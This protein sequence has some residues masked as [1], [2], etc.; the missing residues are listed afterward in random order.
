[1]GDT[2]PT[3][4]SAR[5]GRGARAARGRLLSSG[6]ALAGAVAVVLLSSGC[7]GGGGSSAPD[8][9]T[10]TADPG[11][12]TAGTEPVVEDGDNPRRDADEGQENA[13]GLRFVVPEDGVLDGLLSD[14]TRLGAPSADT[15][16]LLSTS[17]RGTLELLPDGRAFRYTPEPD[18]N[19]EDGFEFGAGDE[20]VLRVT[21]DVTPVP[22]AP[23]FVVDDV[24]LVAERDRPFTR[25]IEARDADGDFLRFE[26]SG[27]PD[28]LALDAESGM[29]GGT[30]TAADVGVT[31]GIALTVIDPSGRRDE[32]GDIVFEVIDVVRPDERP[33]LDLTRFPA[34]LD[35][36]EQQVVEVFDAAVELDG[37]TLA[38]EA[39]PGLGARVDGRRVILE[40]DDVD[41]VTEVVLALTL[42]DRLGAT[43]RADVPLTLYPT[44]PSGRGHT[45][46]GSRTG[47][48]V[49]L[50]VLG[51]GY[52]TD[53]QELLRADAVELIDAMRA[54]PGIV[55]HLGAFNIHVVESVSRDEGALPPGLP[56][57]FH[58]T[59]FSSRY[60]CEGVA[61]LI[62]AD[63]LEAFMQAGAEY[64]VRQVVMS[65][66]DVRFGGS[67]SGGGIAIASRGAAEV[68]LHELGHSL[69]GLA[70]EYVDG[71]L[72]NALAPA[73]VEGLFPNVTAIID[74]AAVPWAR[75][76]EP[77]VAVPSLE[78]E[79]GVGL[80]EGALYRERGVYRPMSTSRMREFERPFGPVNSERWVLALYRDGSTVRDFEPQ[81]FDVEIAAGDSRRFSVTP[82][83]APEVQSIEW[84]L[85]GERVRRA[86]DAR[87]LEIAPPA[88]SHTLR[89]QVRDISGAIRLEPPHSG[90]FD[91]N[92]N[93]EVR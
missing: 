13:A 1:M 71:A 9:G 14:A 69:A 65:V 66:N 19:G 63:V 90:V 58:S 91:W 40:A 24:P 42:T 4:Q 53:Q 83:F 21:I 86:D 6:R 48:G 2:Y 37:Q 60:D 76:I 50:V 70:D 5:Q 72:V 61:Q 88:G 68:A 92:W 33:A 34:T 18:F 12:S 78:G 93:I 43:V 49:H 32:R 57:R 89:L 17:A 10:G 47:P 54:D 26:A 80:F 45:L 84:W 81:A 22:D 51:D 44:S 27:L 36:R 31:E 87:V 52:L 82:F 62:C 73:F 56:E 30:P 41:A 85:N 46:L 20:R 38:V 3:L 79:P 77:E 35:G 55:S 67:G 39:E 75:W 7:E 16:S 23:V 28:W 59:A 74:P 11:D 64:D 15:F 25:A 29:L 8:G